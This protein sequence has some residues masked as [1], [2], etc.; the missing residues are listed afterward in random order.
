MCRRMEALHPVFMSDLEKHGV[1]FIP[2][3]FIPFYFFYL[4]DLILFCLI[5]F[6][7]ILFDPI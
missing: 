4:F 1:R 6:H 7:F 5:L 3:Y 2:F